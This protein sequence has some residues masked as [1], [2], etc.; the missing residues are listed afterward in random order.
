MVASSNFDQYEQ[1]LPGISVF[2]IHKPEK[3][4]VTID[5]PEKLN[6]S[7]RSRPTSNHQLV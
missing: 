4:E 1:V 7:I 5:V 3:L 2:T 6:S